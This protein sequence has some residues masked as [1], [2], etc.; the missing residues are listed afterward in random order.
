MGKRCIICG[1]DAKLQIKGTSDF[2]CNE[3]AA[4]HFDD[5]DVLISVEEQ[6]RKIKKLV[7]EAKQ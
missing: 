6:A 3:C 4:E 1:E 5:V 7:E 2:Y